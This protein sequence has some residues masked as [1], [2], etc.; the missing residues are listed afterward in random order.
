VREDVDWIKLADGR[1][2]WQ[3]VVILIN[4]R[5]PK[6]HG[7]VWPVEEVSASHKIK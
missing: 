4:L 7:I 1:V 5:V 2:Q 6:M 3:A